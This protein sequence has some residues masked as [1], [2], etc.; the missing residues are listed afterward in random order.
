MLRPASSFTYERAWEYWCRRCR[1]ARDDFRTDGGGRLADGHRRPDRRRRTGRAHARRRP[2][3]ARRALHA[4]RDERRRRNSCRRWSAAT[5]APWRSSAAWGWRRRC[6]PPACRA[7]VPMDVYIAL[8][9][10]RAA[11][12]ALAVSVGGRGAAEIAACNDGIDAARA[13]PAHLA[14]HA[15]AAAQVRGRDSFP[16]VT[17]ATA[18]N[19]CR[20]RRMPTSVTAR[21]TA[22]DGGSADPRAISRRLRR[23]RQRGA[24]AARHR[25]ARRGATSCGCCQALYHCADLF[26]ASRSAAGRARAV[27]TTSPTSNRRSSSCRTRPALDAACAVDDAEDMA[28]AVRA[29]RSACR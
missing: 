11:A 3:P 24:P 26:D 25:A 12:A 22:T 6:A 28:R 2:R 7:D 21:C 19:S 14:V 8:R 9:A 23:R 15:R 20:C 5:R 10:E 1:S 18:A 29:R 16:C 27:T 4:D 13:V 17:C